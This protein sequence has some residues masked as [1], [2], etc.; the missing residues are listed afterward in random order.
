MVRVPVQAADARW[1]SAAAQR[2]NEE[3]LN[4]NARDRIAVREGEKKVPVGP[5]T[6]LRSRAFMSLMCPCIRLVW[7]S[8][9]DTDPI[10]FNPINAVQLSSSTDSSLYSWLANHTLGSYGRPSLPTVWPRT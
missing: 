2:E 10:R 3:T 1:Q 6:G 5:V 4:Q 9:A 7:H 8:L